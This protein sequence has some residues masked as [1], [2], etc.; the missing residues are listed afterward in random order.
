MNKI[1]VVLINHFS[2][3]EIRASLVLEAASKRNKYR[4]IGDWNTAIIDGLKSRK[5]IDLYVISPHIGMKKKVQEFEREGV[6]Y[7]FYRKELPFPWG[8]IESHLLSQSKRDFPRN[9][10][11]VKRIIKRI[12]PDIVNLI[13]A[14][15]AY[16]SITALDV[17][18]VPV[19][20]HLQTVYANP[21]R[22]K[23]AGNVDKKRWDVELR[24]FHKTPY[25]ACPGKKYYDLVKGYEPNAIVLPRLW[26]E[27][28]FPNILE[29]P[30]KYDFA[31]FARYLNKN[32]GFD[33]ALEAM[34]LFIKKHP[35]VRFLA[36]GSWES[37][38]E[39]YQQRIKKLNLENNL[40]IHPS[41]TE[42]SDMLQYVK[43]ARFALLPIT[44]DVISGTIIEALRMGMP[45]ITCRTSGTPSLNEKRETVL[46][47]EIKDS[48]GLYD[49]ML[50]LYESVELQEQLKQNASLYLQERDESNSRN[51]DGM[52]AQYKAVMNHYYNGVPIPTSM[53]YKTDENI[54]YSR[55]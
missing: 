26:P 37:D 42:Y 41:F 19:L 12:N 46:I 11:I 25:L 30:K 22:S 18:N 8:S 47:S 24:I 51:V 50:R 52:V 9:R 4:D 6:H 29:T 43:Q 44:M 7:F 45:V 34:G 17:E 39:F 1:K 16:Y 10:T 53:L 55:K 31:Y 49:N 21:E 32:K 5:D 54:D 20:V 35:E 27:A 28:R 23:N 48:E 15:N 40:E 3:P 2:N 33:N 13:G 14:E 38:K 36:V